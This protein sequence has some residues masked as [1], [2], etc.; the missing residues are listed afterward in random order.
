MAMTEYTEQY[1]ESIYKK[2]NAEIQSGLF[3]YRR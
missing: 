1:T 2:T 3:I